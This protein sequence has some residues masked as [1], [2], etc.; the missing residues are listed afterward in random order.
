VLGAAKILFKV[1]PKFLGKSQQDFVFIVDRVL[2]KGY[3][4]VPRAIGAKG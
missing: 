4:L 3:E 2:E 1:F